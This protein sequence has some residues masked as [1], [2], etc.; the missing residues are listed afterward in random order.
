MKKKKRGH[1]VVYL[2]ILLM[3]ITF[4]D[5][6]RTS[7][8][9]TSGEEVSFYFLYGSEK[10]GW[11]EEVTP[12][13]EK[14][15]E[16][17]HPDM[18][19]KMIPKAM[20]SR[21]SMIQI[22]TGKAKPIVWSPAA[23]IWI[24]LFKYLWSKA[25]GNNIIYNKDNISALVKSPVILGS[26]EKYLDSHELKGFQDLYNLA[27]GDLKFAHTSP[28]L[29]NSGF[30]TMILEVAA[31]AGK[32]PK[33]LTMSDLENKT[34]QEWIKKIESKS[35][36][37]GSSTGFLARMAGEQG[38]EAVNVIVVYENLIIEENLKGI[39]QKWGQ[40]LV[41]VYPEEG[42]LMTDHPYVILNGS[43][44]SD[45]QLLIAKEYLKFLLSPEIQ[46]LAID[47]GFRPVRTDIFNDPSVIEKFNEV[48]NPNNGVVANLTIKEL[49]PPEEGQVLER[50]P[51]VWVATKAST[52]TEGYNVLGPSIE[53]S[54]VQGISSMILLILFITIKKRKKN[55]ISRD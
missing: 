4:L 55:L 32:E 15:F 14:E 30:M 46:Q 16:S 23:S 26:W 39:E 9:V 13:F 20:G 33:N 19:I 22:L 31:A 37:Y 7:S 34:V 17:R 49:E 51:D 11:I 52:G 28:Q 48:F 43:W 2:L 24:P 8:T 53:D 12:L 42:T 5:I 21:E 47:Y 27:E 1:V 40:K 6:A 29:S 18:K 35:V 41:A 10:K 38:P 54:L 25:Y 36:F 44:I 3:F 45:D 50:I